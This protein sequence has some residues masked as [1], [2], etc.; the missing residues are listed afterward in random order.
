MVAPARSPDEFD[1]PGLRVLVT[2]LDRRARLNKPIGRRSELASA[3]GLTRQSIS[4]W[5]RVPVEHCPRIHDL[6]D[7]PLY[8]LRPD[9]YKAPVRKV[10]A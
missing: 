8:K 2:E 5:Q 6:L 3:L 7:I 10:K 1:D 9:V 4:M